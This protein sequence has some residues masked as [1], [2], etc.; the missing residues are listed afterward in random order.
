MSHRICQAL[1]VLLTMG[2]QVA[3]A[4]DWFVDT[5]G[6]DGNDC[7][8][9]GPSN[10]CLTIQAAIDRA[11]PGDTIHV[12]AGTYPEPAPG[13]LVIGTTLTLLG[14]QNGVD[15]RERVAPESVVADP[16]GTAII[17]DEVVID[18]FT[19]QE[20]T[21]DF[22]GFGVWM[23]AATAGTQ[24]LNNII[25]GNVI[26][27]GLSNT[28]SSRAIIRH[29]LI[30]NNNQP[31]PASGTG[32]Y[33]DQFVSGGPLKNVLIEENAFVGNDDAGIDV[34][35]TDDANGVSGIDVST[36]S[37][38]ANGRA[39]VLFNTFRSSIHGN[40]ITNSTYPLSAAIRVFDNNRNLSILDN[41]FATGVFHAIRV[42]D[43]DL[44]DPGNPNPSANLV[45][46]Q[47]NIAF[48][49][50]DGM[51]VDPGSHVGTVN[52]ECNWWNSPTGPTNDGNP[53]GTGERVDG[54]AGFTPWL[55]APAPSGEC[56]GGPP[57]TPGK[58]TGGGH[59]GSDPS[60]PKGRA[61]FGFEVKCCAPTGRLEYNDHQAGVRIEAQSVS[62]LVISSPGTACPALPGSRHARFTGMAEV[63]RS[64]GTTTEPVTV[65][66]DD[67][68]E[69]GKADTFGI[70]TTSYSNGPSTLTGGNIQIHQ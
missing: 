16:A 3:A 48:F 5:S 17:A 14:E 57:S 51:L 70:R 37:F 42:S 53:A 52:A 19:F 6:N 25:Q 41:D 60:H 65:D 34:S 31:G 21:T 4:A 12:A 24:I 39:V 11:S 35:N 10:A 69:P 56:V 49:A 23:G 22:T 36:N 28:G 8:A 45:I 40:R 20:S 18:G 47:N 68:G 29:N 30:Q 59:V 61:T 15:A 44:V 55:I 9:P 2:G 32:I 54:D 26:G 43:L 13:P 66:V 38:D 7:T 1:L 64:T 62:G 67:C 33:T 63:M 27:I 46:H 50:G 58:V